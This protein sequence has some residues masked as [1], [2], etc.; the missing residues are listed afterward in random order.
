MEIKVHLQTT[1]LALPAVVGGQVDLLFSAEVFHR[2]TFA[3]SP[4][5][6]RKSFTI[7]SGFLRV[8]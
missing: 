4:S 1:V 7:C 5:D 3:S 8:I 6:L 2:L